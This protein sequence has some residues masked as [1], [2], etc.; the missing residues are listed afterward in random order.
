MENDKTK[1]NSANL[2]EFIT[3]LQKAKEQIPNSQK[4]LKG[5]PKR[6]EDYLICREGIVAETDQTGLKDGWSIVKE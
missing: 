5:K 1:S 3:G 4:M 2:S 6:A